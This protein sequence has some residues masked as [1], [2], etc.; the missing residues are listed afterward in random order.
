MLIRL[1]GEK[2]S[3]LDLKKHFSRCKN[4]ESDYIG[5]RFEEFVELI[6]LIYQEKGL[7]DGG[8]HG[9]SARLSY[10]DFEAAYNELDPFLKGRV[11]LREF[12]DF[13]RK[14]DISTDI[15]SDQDILEIF[16]EL[17]QAESQG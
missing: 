5:L 1:F 15:L 14:N 16:Y 2:P 10:I 4:R 11:N 6:S 17:S 12:R 3:S 7:G 9:T 8:Y 13:F